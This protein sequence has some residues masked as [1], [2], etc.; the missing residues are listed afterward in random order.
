MKMVTMIRAC[1]MTWLAL[2][3]A[4][5]MGA[6]PPNK[7][8]GNA[9][10]E[11]RKLVYHRFLVDIVP[12]QPTPEELRKKLAPLEVA[13]IQVSIP[14]ARYRKVFGKAPPF[15]KHDIYVR[16]RDSYEMVER[17]IKARPGVLNVR[18]LPNEI[19]RTL[20]ELPKPR[21]PEPAGTVYHYYN[22]NIDAPQASRERLRKLL[23]PLD[24]VYHRYPCSEAWFHEVFGKQ[25]PFL[26]CRL[27]I[28][29]SES[30]EQVERVLKA[31]SGVTIA[32][33]PDPAKRTVVE[34]TRKIWLERD[35]PKP[36]E[37]PKR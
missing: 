10:P 29:S 2:L 34:I 11:A 24:L 28:R 4:F 36:T 3:V 18:S 7:K 17:D 16:S 30:Y 20:E 13:R 12:P 31:K 32:S 37:L 14:E 23:A 1:A 9:T 15:V 27:C 19:R 5:C 25:P 26:F 35:P 33:R 8:A 21:V 22:F 6:A